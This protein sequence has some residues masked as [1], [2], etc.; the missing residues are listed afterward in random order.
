MKKIR[1]KYDCCGKHGAGKATS[2]GFI[3]SCFYFYRLITD[4][5]QSDFFSKVG[6]EV[7]E[8]DFLAAKLIHIKKTH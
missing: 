5:Q 7:F 4:L 6:V 3:A 2:A 1:W 8:E